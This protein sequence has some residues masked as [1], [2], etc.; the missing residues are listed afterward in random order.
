MAFE[1]KL[2]R[3]GNSIKQRNNPNPIR[4]LFIEQFGFNHFLNDEI[5]QAIDIFAETGINGFRV[6]GFWPYGRGTETEPYVRE[7]NRYK[8]DRFNDAYFSYLQRWVEYAYEKAIVVRYELFDRCGL[9]TGEVVSDHHPYNQL[10]GRDRRKFSDLRNTKLVAIQKRYLDKVVEVLKP[11]PNVIFGIM[12]EFKSH[13][14]W[15]YEMARHVKTLAPEHLISGSEE[16]SPAVRD[17]RGD[18]W[19]VHTGT[20]DFNTGQS[21][22]AKD[23]AALRQRTGQNKVL[24]FSTDGFGD[25]GMARETPNDMRRLAE[26]ANH[27]G[28]QLLSFLDQQAYDDNDQGTLPGK[29]SRLNVPTYQALVN[30]FRPSPLGTVKPLGTSAR[31]CAFCYRRP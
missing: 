2:Y 13:E 12:N 14:D 20:Y 11:Y 28:I 26:D 9:T 17:S 4:I 3:Q 24:G 22:I 18:M 10:V 29:A 1:G 31:R 27:A 23:V 6:F 16:D 21:H 8:L 15:H 7:G 5:F 25:R 19:W 30:T